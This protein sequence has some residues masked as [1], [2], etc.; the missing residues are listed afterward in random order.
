MI[1]YEITTETEVFEPNADYKSEGAVEWNS[2]EDLPEG[3]H[4]IVFWAAYPDEECEIADP[5]VYQYHLD[6]SKP[7]SF[8]LI[9]DTEEEGWRKYFVISDRNGISDSISGIKKV[10]YQINNW[11]VNDFDNDIV[12]NT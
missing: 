11:G 9:T 2:V 4:Y 3:S 12:N 10:S 5:E 8:E 6:K 1:T 7:E